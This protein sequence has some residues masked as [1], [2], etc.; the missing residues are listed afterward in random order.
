MV[1]MYRA[2]EGER[3]DALFQDP[4]SLK[5]AGERGQ[6][7]M[8][9]LW[10]ANWA[11]ARQARIMIWHMAVRTYVIDQLIM[12]A[13]QRGV[14]AI[15]NLGAGLDTRPY[16]M[17]VPDT[18]QWIEVDY[19]H[20]I[21][22]KEATLATD[23]PRCK[24]ERIKLDLTD[25]AAR[26]RLFGSINERFGNTLVLTEGVIPYL[27]ESNVA[28]LADDLCAQAGFKQWIV[29]Y[30]SR[31]AIAYRARSMRAQMQNAPFQFDP[32]DYFDFFRQHGWQAQQ[33]RYLWDEGV[34]SGARC[35]S[36]LL[37]LSG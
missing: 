13:I 5:L 21:E 25:R 30:F 37:L 4:L 17:A 31:Q 35:R 9:G 3:A 32:A 28:M 8:R 12:T 14:T 6:Q 1:A 10:G 36:P 29:D 19:P 16:R 15:L 2:K 27:T 20:V 7:I 23:Q 26:L 33:T 18:L 11:N 34:T 22:L 24:L